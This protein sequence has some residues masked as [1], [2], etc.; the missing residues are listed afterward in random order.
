MTV[1]A[2]MTVSGNAAAAGSL[3]RSGALIDAKGIVKI[4]PTVSGEPVLALDRVD[5]SVDDGEF[6]CLVGPSGC[7]KST[8]ARLIVGLDRPSSG[9]FAFERQVYSGRDM[10][11]LVRRE[12]SF[13]FPDPA[14][15]F[16]PRLTVGES[17]A[18][19]L[20]LEPQRLIEE[21][22][23]RILE[24]VGSVGLPQDILGRPPHEVTIGQLQR[25]A[26]A[27]ALITRPKLIVLDE[28]TAMLDVTERGALLVMLNRLRADFGLSLLILSGDI[29]VVRTIAD[30][31]LVLDHGKIVESGSPGALIDAP[32]HPVTRA[33]VAA[34][35]PEIGIVPI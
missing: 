15:S 4:Y 2:T 30:R 34:R 20:R 7:G 28:P 21:L 31:M 29:D 19:P 13:V 8:L 1:A 33:L 26:I 23:Q 6:V 10:P 17:V 12:I 25:L 14:L 3:T 9:E 32:E 16:N 18:E 5:M 11:L 35:L 24:V 22:A 27:R